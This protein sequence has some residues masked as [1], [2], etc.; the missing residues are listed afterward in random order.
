M[1]RTYKQK[2]KQ[3]Y[4]KADLRERKPMLSW[5]PNKKMVVLYKGKVIHF[6]ATG[7][8]DYT[9]HRDKARRR[10]WYARHSKILNKQGKPVIK[11]KNSPSYWSAKILW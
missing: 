5:L 7:Y 1:A 4:S 9:Q 8:S 10:R 3:A 6:G 11:D 2:Y